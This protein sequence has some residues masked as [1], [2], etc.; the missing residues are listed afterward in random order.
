MTPL[1]V[2]LHKCLVDKMVRI[3]RKGVA[4]VETSKGILLVSGRR[5]I[6][7]FPGGGANK[8]ESRKIATIREL[9]EETGI[10]AKSA[11]YLFSYKGK[12]WHDHKGRKVRNHAKVFLITAKGNPKPRHEIKYIGWWKPGSRLRISKRTKSVIEKYLREKLD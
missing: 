1:N 6:F 3:R 11:K 5:K 10:K 8:G 9:K 12:Y 4:I 2:E 7:S